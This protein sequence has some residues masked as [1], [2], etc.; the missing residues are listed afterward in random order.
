[1]A[2]AK[3]TGQPT[4]G[5]AEHPGEERDKGKPEPGSGLDRRIDRNSATTRQSQDNP[6]GTVDPQ[7][8]DPKHR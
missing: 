5:T 8:L 7:P 3:R 1:M 4:D 2:D 6:G